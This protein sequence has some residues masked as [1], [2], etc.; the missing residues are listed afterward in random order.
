MLTI[1]KIFLTLYLI[2]VFMTA[3]AATHETREMS[4][5]EFLVHLFFFFATIHF[6]WSV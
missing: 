4:L 6:V 5:L 1:L 3:P 2:G